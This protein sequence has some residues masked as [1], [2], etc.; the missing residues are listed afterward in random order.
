MKNFAGIDPDLYADAAVG[1]LCLFEAVIDVGT[2]SLKGNGSLVIGFFTGD[3]GAAYTAGDLNFD[4]LWRRAS[5]HG[6]W[7][8]S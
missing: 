5:L 4:A 8:F 6:R 3:L 1:G 2:E 7:P